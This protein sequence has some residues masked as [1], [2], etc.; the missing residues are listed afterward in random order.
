MEFVTPQDTPIASVLVVD[1][2]QS[3]WLM[4][5]SILEPFDLELIYAPNGEI[6]LELASVVQFDVILM[7][8]CLPGLQGDEVTRRIRAAQ[9][10]NASASII[11]FTSEPNLVDIRAGYNGMLSKPFTP[12]DLTT[13]ILIAL[14]EQ[15]AVNAGSPP[16]SGAAYLH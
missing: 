14:V 5:R 15:E 13:A 12:I 1:D 10:E 3:N 8:H 6:A 7:D 11:A 9:N 4:V 16:A 2:C